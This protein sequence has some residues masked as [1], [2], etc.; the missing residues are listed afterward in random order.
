MSVPST[1]SVVGRQR[2]GRLLHE[3][4]VADTVGG[5]RRASSSP[6]MA[7]SFLPSRLKSPTSILRH[8]AADDDVARRL[9]GAVTVAEH[10][11]E[12]VADDAGRLITGDVVRD[13]DVEPGVVV[14]IDRDHDHGRVEPGRVGEVHGSGERAVAVALEQREADRRVVDRDHQI[15]APVA[16][17]VGG[18]EIL[19]PGRHRVGD[20]RAEPTRAVVQ[21]DVGDLCA[22]ARQVEVAVTVEVAGDVLVA[23][24]RVVGGPGEGRGLRG[25]AGGCAADEAGHQA[26]GTD[27]AGAPDGGAVPRNG[28]GRGSGHL[29][30][31][32][33]GFDRGWLLEPDFTIRRWSYDLSRGA[34]RKP[35]YA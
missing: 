30:S 29:V 14:E 34:S 21:P 27:E 31:P 22:R 15:E 16:V 9:E 17:E 1:P 19:R 11:R 5:G 2:Q 13:H 20:F 24:E 25:G 12:H 3:R 28:Q 6:A 4:A 35:R 23:D 8:A 26:D 32:Q 33:S 7:R 10:H 18:R